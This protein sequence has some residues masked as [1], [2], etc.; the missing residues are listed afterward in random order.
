MTLFDGSYVQVFTVG[1]AEIAPRAMRTAKTAK[2]TLPADYF[3]R[4]ERKTLAFIAKL[5]GKHGQ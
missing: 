2:H 3:F 1:V 4:A 5:R